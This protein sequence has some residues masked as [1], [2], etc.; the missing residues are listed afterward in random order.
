M[1]GFN[2][3]FNPRVSHVPLNP[4][5]QE[6]PEIDPTMGGTH[7][8]SSRDLVDPDNEEQLNGV[9]SRLHR[10]GIEGLIVRDRWGL[11]HAR[12][13]HPALYDATLGPMKPSRV[14]IDYLLPIFTNA[15]GEDDMEHTRAQRT[16]QPA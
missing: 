14:G 12:Q 2:S 3:L 13:M 1:K 7:I 5:F 8:G 9:M 4:L 15:I 10:L 6:I 11:I 16:R